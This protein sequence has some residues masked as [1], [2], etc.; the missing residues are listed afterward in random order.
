MSDMERRDTDRRT[1]PYTLPL[2]LIA[3]RREARL[4][5]T[6]LAERLGIARSTVVRWELG[7]VTPKRKDVSAWALAT[8][9]DAEWLWS[10]VDPEGPESR[11]YAASIQ[12][13]RQH[14]RLTLADRPRILSAA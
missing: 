8:G 13:Y 1:L 12:Q 5:Q 6:E 10:G 3:T 9:Y 7:E 4:N 11:R 2:R 14:S